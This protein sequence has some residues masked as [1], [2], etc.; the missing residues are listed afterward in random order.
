MKRHT[1]AHY[2]STPES[3]ARHGTFIVGAAYSD[4]D[5]RMLHVMDGEVDEVSLYHSKLG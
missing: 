5:D 1:V 3:R 2:R 4:A